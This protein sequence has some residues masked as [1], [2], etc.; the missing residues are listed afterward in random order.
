MLKKQ[1]CSYLANVCFVG[2]DG[3]VRSDVSRVGILSM[4][5]ISH[6][7]CVHVSFRHGAHAPGV[8]INPG[9]GEHDGSGGPLPAGAEHAGGSWYSRT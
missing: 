3:S 4:Q 8:R 5:Q 9:H 1:T 7:V 2:T 6:C